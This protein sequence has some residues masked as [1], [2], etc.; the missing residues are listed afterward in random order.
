MKIGMARA[1]L[2][3]AVV[4]ALVAE[5]LPARGGAASWED[6]AGDATQ[7]GAYPVPMP[8]E[9]SYDI[10]KIALNNEGGTVTWT[11]E[12]PGLE[13]GRPLVSTGLDFRFGF[14][15]GDTGY[16]MIITEDSSGEQSTRFALQSDSIAI[17]CEK[18]AGEIDRE[19][20]TILVTAPVSDLSKALQSTKA[21]ALAGQKWTQLFVA[22]MRPLRTEPHGTGPLLDADTAK[23]PDGLTIAF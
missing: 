16:Q 21:P 10:T 15:L 1:L 4:S 20:K 19:S 8:N 12:V 7:L 18:C 23:A 3:G 11:A 5:A 9:A 17:P 22:A 6:P 2:L 14:N 13:E